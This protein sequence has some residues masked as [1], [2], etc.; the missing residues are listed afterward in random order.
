MSDDLNRRFSQD[1]RIVGE[2]SPATG[3]AMLRGLADAHEAVAL[4][5]ADN[6]MVE[7]PGVDFFG[8]AHEVHPLAKRVL[9]V[10]RDYTARSPLVDAMTL[11]QADY[12]ITKPWMLEQDLYRQVSEF[13]AE[14]AR[15]R[16]QASSSST[17]SAPQA[18]AAPMTCATC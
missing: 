1:F 4:L 3:L 5:I 12:H 17:S 15:T 7:M 11:G 16:R 6:D 9:L 14:W 8:H 2:T 13:L 18:T 10:E